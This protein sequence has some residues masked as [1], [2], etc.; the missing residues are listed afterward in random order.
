MGC[1]RA[2]LLL[3]LYSSGKRRVRYFGIDRASEC[4]EA[5]QQDHPEQ[6]FREADLGQDSGLD[7][8][9]QF[10]VIAMIA[11]IEHLPDPE[12]VLRRLSQY[13]TGRGRLIITTP[14]R[15]TE[16]LHALG[17]RIGFCSPEAA[18]EHVNTFPDHAFFRKQE[19]FSGLRLDHYE[20]F[21]LGLNQLAVLSRP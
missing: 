5:N 11:V 12:A 10:D 15:G 20:R 16:K 18:A 14:R 9:E 21:L 6:R 13:L 3:T 8:E 17:A 2:S 7:F 4:V 19:D 1:G